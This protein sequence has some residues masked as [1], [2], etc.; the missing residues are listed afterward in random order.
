M[1]D[2]ASM[3][4]RVAEYSEHLTLLQSRDR[5]CWHASTMSHLPKTAKQRHYKP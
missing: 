3:M 1:P 4:G 5:N 2:D